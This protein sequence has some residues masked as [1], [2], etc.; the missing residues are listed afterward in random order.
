MKSSAM[1]MHKNCTLH[2]EPT[3]VLEALKMY[4]S[5]I[6]RPDVVMNLDDEAPLPDRMRFLGSRTEHLM[7][8]GLYD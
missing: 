6:S 8:F 4:A 5:H 1:K 3:G 7:F 2:T